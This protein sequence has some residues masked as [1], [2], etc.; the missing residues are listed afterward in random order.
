M[1]NLA[2]SFFPVSRGQSGWKCVNDTPASN[3]CH[4]SGVVCNSHGN[5]TYLA[6]E[7]YGIT[8]T[9]PTVLGSLSSL[10]ALY[11]RFNDLSGVVPS[12]LCNMNLNQLYVSY[13]YWWYYYNNNKLTCY[14]PCLRSILSL[15]VDN[16]AVCGPDY[17]LE[18]VINID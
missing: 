6:L 5:V 18:G 14:S 15:G 9:I 12:F 10:T 1:C 16:I 3:Y 17:N 7:N 11:L 4:W 8:G 13:Y 2:E